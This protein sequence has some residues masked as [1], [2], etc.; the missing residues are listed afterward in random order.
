MIIF[1]GIRG[2][3]R[4]TASRGPRVILGE[5]YNI[6]AV[7]VIAERGNSQTYIIEVIKSEAPPVSGGPL[8]IFQSASVGNNSSVSSPSA[9]GIGKWK[10][11]LIFAES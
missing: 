10:N 6:I 9:A 5:G 2:T 11:L 4:I 3:T 7:D 1:S 8:L